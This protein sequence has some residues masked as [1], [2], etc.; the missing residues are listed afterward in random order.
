M[1]YQ[2]TG[3]QARAERKASENIRQQA[4]KQ[5]EGFSGIVSE[6]GGGKRSSTSAY[7]KG[8]NVND[9][10]YNE[11]AEL[12]FGDT[13]VSINKP[14]IAAPNKLNVS[15]STQAPQETSIQRQNVLIDTQAKQSETNFTY[16]NKDKSYI[17]SVQDVLARQKQTTDALDYKKYNVSNPFV[18]IGFSGVREVITW[19]QTF[20]NIGTVTSG[21][22][23]YGPQSTKTFQTP[24][25]LSS[26]NSK[27]LTG[28]GLGMT[29]QS[30][31]QTFKQRDIYEQGLALQKE[32]A[33]KTDKSQKEFNN[34]YG[35]L[36]NSTSNEFIGTAEQYNQY[37]IDFSNV[38]S[39]YNSGVSALT[40]SGLGS[41]NS[42]GQFNF[43]IPSSINAQIY[44]NKDS[45]TF[46]KLGSSSIIIAGKTAEALAG[47]FALKSVGAIGAIGRG[48]EYLSGSGIVG[49]SV[50]YTGVAGLTAAPVVLGSISGYKEFKEAGASG[51]T[52]A[53]QGAAIGLG[54]LSGFTTGASGGEF[55]FVPGIKYRNIGIPSEAGAYPTK[56]LSFENPF[57]KGA[58]PLIT[59][60]NGKVSFGFP[61]EIG[62]KTFGIV[63][64]APGDYALQA[65]TKTD[66]S[67][68]GKAISTG[69]NRLGTEQIIFEESKGLIEGLSSVKINEVNKINF[70]N[71]GVFRNLKSQTGKDIIQSTFS[72]LGQEQKGFKGFWNAVTNK[73][74]DRLYGSSTI[75]TEGGFD[76][77]LTRVKGEFGDF[78]LNFRD[79]GIPRAEKLFS[80]LKGAG[81]DVR[82]TGSLIEIRNPKTK[83]F[84]HAFDFHGVD[85]PDLQMSSLKFGIKGVSNKDFGLN[86]GTI[87]GQQLRQSLVDKGSATIQLRANKAGQLFFSPPDYRLKDVSDFISIS[88][89]LNT[90]K[91]GNKFGGKIES[92]KNVLQVAYPKIKFTPEKDLIFGGIG[93][94]KA[95]SLGSFSSIGSLNIKL[96]SK[97]S[98]FSSSRSMSNSLSSMSSFSS[99]SSS[100]SSSSLSSFSPSSF[101]S[102]SGFSPSGFG[103]PSSFSPSG[104]S[105]PSSPSPSK[106]P[107]PFDYPSP[108]ISNMGFPSMPSLGGWSI[109]NQKGRGRKNTF[110]I[111]PSF[112]SIVENIKMKSS[113]KVSKSLGVTP[114]QSRGLYTGKG[115]YYKLTDL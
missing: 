52:G 102:P 61:K 110:N 79:T 99:P 71:S 67:F 105:P 6:S 13:L 12:I 115:K 3:E 90:V 15:V 46:E 38:N 29:F 111:A 42:T 92:L 66:V 28:L 63:D 87:K 37:Q 80:S 20:K 26:S 35:Q 94:S 108:S 43:N 4:I 104:F 44:A 60:S 109:P 32:F 48:A 65:G 93:K 50:V 19:G 53:I 30:I 39:S 51:T 54:E 47:G 112:T 45:T 7:I 101:S 100:P 106:S 56:T 8:K 84:E 22:F 97:V 113:L 88:E 75:S 107:S 5:S 25:E 36:I 62:P 72:E 91:G 64:I 27:S 14:N 49:K 74:L 10:K 40:K 85:T 73:G 11:T 55:L 9:L 95:G 68:F 23:G 57:G 16:L 114:F 2:S 83:L 76:T 89:K 1:G 98:G 17:Q 24:G 41:T 82:L 77:S 96:P 103:S 31:G 86:I 78:D 34:T 33:T 70:E 21:I 81:E 69:G 18:A 58:Y 59:Q